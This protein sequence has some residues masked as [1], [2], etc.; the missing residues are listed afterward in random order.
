ML[1][2]RCRDSGLV[3]VCAALSPCRPL[4]RTTATMMTPM[5]RSNRAVT[6]SP[7]SNHPRNTT[8]TGLVEARVS[9]VAFNSQKISGERD[10][11][12][13]NEEVHQSNPGAQGGTKQVDLAP[14]AGERNPASHNHT[15]RKTSACLCG[16]LGS[17][18][19]ESGYRARA[20]VQIVCLF[21]RSRE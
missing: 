13:K 15:P 11:G 20:K 18:P 4:M 14:L 2:A 17:Q 7:A 19:T 6:A 21:Q 1:K 9:V 5:A 3:R 8:T 12:P 10:E 16:E